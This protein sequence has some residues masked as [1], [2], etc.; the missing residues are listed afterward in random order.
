MHLEKGNS[1]KLHKFNH[2]I[3]ESIHRQWT[4]Q[5]QTCR[6]LVCIIRWSMNIYICVTHVYLEHVFVKLISKTLVMHH[7]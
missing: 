6:D 5:I 4:K 3:K 1:Q 7:Q 2:F